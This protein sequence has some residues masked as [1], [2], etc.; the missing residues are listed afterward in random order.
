[1]DSEM[2]RKLTCKLT[3][4]KMLRKNIGRIYIGARENN[5]SW[6]L[7]DGGDSIDNDIKLSI[8]EEFAKKILDEYRSKIEE[9][10]KNIILG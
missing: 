6:S 4:I 10:I 7:Y 5:K 8:E 1:M 2:L 3:I 9:Q